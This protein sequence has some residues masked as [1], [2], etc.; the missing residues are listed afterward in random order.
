MQK[1]GYALF[2]TAIGR[3]GIAWT[4]RGVC[5]VQLPHVDE[6]D[7][8]RRLARHFGAV[9][10]VPPP[11]VQQA[12]ERIARLLAGGSDDLA[13]IALD[14]DGVPDFERRVYDE[15]RRIPPGRTATYGEIAS[16]LGEPGAARA[17]G[18]ALGRNPYPLIVPCHR[19]LAAG[20]GYGGFSAPGG[21]TTK[22]RLLAIER[23]R[24]HSGP[25]LFDTD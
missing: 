18:R 1:P 10:A 8:G 5:A 19:V 12:I 17:V 20:G 16:A 13:D 24:P 11:A 14:I 7:T 23:A 9:E 2:A 3:C 6:A 22:L 4:D 21:V 15:A 25:D